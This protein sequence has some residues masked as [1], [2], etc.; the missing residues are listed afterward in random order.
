M[1]SASLFYDIYS[2]TLG[3][4][5]LTFSGR[6]LTGASFN[7]PRDIAYRKDSA[8][9]ALINEL[10]SYFKGINVNFSQKVRF[11][12]GTEFEQKVWLSLKD[13]PYG[14]TRTYKWVAEK[15]GSP[16]ASR[17][18]G[19]ALS[20]NPVTLIL[21]CHRVVESDGSIGGYSSGINIKI[22]ILE[23]EYYAKMNQAK[24]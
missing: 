21:P 5:Y 15:V 20:K 11:L 17:A 12:T 3:N 10:T 13:I 14:E 24:S 9:R 18:V 6:F 8:P 7:K 16:S 1:K 22:R 4:L 19:R 23:L 2:S